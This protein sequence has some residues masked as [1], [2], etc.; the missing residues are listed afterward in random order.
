M[1]LNPFWNLAIGPAI[2]KIIGWLK[3]L[4]GL[5]VPILW[6]VVTVTLNCVAVL[7][8]NYILGWNLDAAGLAPYLVTGLVSTE[9]SHKLQK[10]KKKNP[11]SEVTNVGTFI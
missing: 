6:T 1:E 8:A 5:D 2:W 7:A 9:I 10:T 11:I 3:G 4:A